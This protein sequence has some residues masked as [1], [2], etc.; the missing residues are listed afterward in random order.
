MWLPALELDQHCFPASEP[1]GLIFGDPHLRNLSRVQ[2]SSSSHTSTDH[3]LCLAVES[4]AH[5]CRNLGFSS[6]LVTSRGSM[7]GLEIVT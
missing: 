3:S 6:Q 1:S 5:S 7:Y 4:E 2:P